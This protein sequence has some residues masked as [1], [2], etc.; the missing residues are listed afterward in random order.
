MDKTQ[1]NNALAEIFKVVSRANKYIDETAPWVLAKDENNRTRLATVLYN[2]LE[3]IRIVSTLLSAFMPTTMPRA[4]EQIG[5]DEAAATYDNADK[6]GVLPLD[7]T[8]K[9][10]E[11][12][13]PRIDVE[14]EIEELN[15]IIKNND[16][17][18]EETKKLREEIEGVA[19]I[20]I[21]DFGKV[22]LRVAEIK[23]CEP[24]KKAKKLLK[25]TVFDG[26]KE[27]TVASGIAKYYK[28]EELVGK[29]IILVSNLKPAKLCGV[30]SCGM[31]LAA[32]CGND[33]KVIFVDDMPAGAKIS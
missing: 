5:A 30:E 12:L 31:I 10:G 21:D 27:R 8:V 29:K 33:I 15:S 24:I 13:F 26:V 17:E 3:T 9:K 28:P 14:K 6:F 4:L 11:A 32:T 2:L 25:L 23:A 20:G 18:S 22:D 1:L 16:T 7:V 19:Q